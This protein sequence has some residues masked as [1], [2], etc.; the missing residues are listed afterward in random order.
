MDNSNTP[1]KDDTQEEVVDLSQVTVGEESGP[2]GQDQTP[3]ATTASPVTLQGTEEIIVNQESGS[4]KP[5]PQPQ[6]Q[7]QFSPLSQPTPPPQSPLPTAAPPPPQ[8]QPAPLS[9]A[10]SPPSG[11]PAPEPVVSAPPPVGQGETFM[12]EEKNGGGVFGILKKILPIF[13]ILLLLVGGGLAAY[14]F[15]L[16]R[17]GEPEEVTLTY[18]GLWEEENLLAPIIADY[19]KDNPNVKI[20]YSRQSPKDYRERLQSAFAQGKGPDVFRFHNTWVP[21]FKKELS[22]V[23][24]GVFDAAS[25]EATFYPVARVDLRQ[26]NNYLGV[27]LEID[28]LG[29]FINEE[30]FRTAG[31][32]VPK[33]WDELRQT[34]LDLTVK[35]AVGKIQIAGAALGRT[36][37]IDHW[38]DILALMMLQNGADLTSPTGELAEDALDYFTIFSKRDRIWDETL[39]SSTLAFAGG[40]LAMYLA[41]SWQA[42]EIK[43]ISPDLEFSVAPVPQLP[44]TNITWASYWV[45]GVGEKS[46]VKDEAWDFVKY[47]SQRETMEKLY[48][49]EA[50]VRLFGEPYSRVDMASKLTGDQYAGVFVEQAPQARSGYLSSRTFDNGINDKMIKYFEDAVN[51]VNAGTSAKEALATAAQGVA[52]ISAQYGVGPAVVR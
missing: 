28:G 35:D 37:N 34:A 48:Q 33:T 52:Q 6:N 49:E 42:F 15:L 17:F 40:R 22:P 24:A 32:T 21:M 46:K 47:L 4:Q 5:P 14:K 30:I 11:A 19:Q 3:P 23:P 41:P 38:S 50:K 26:G 45:E 13:L 43:K 9:Q 25:F 36:E 8:P 39:P 44:E 10:V 16:P 7:P 27:P 1:P 29:L 20:I 51:A 31:K 2:P 12:E 18:W